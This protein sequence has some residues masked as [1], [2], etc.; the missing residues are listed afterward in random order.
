MVGLHGFE[1]VDNVRSITELMYYSDHPILITGIAYCI[2]MS[3][4]NNLWP[5]G[6]QP[7]ASPVSPT[8]C[9]S[10]LT[11][12]FFQSYF[13]LHFFPLGG[14]WSSLSSRDGWGGASL[15]VEIKVIKDLP[16]PPPVGQL[17]STPTVVEELESPTQTAQ[18]PPG[19]TC[20]DQHHHGGCCAH[21]FLHHSH[22]PATLS[23]FTVSPLTD[24][25]PIHHVSLV[26][27]EW[28]NRVHH[29]H[30]VVFNHC[31]CQ[32]ILYKGK[33]VHLYSSI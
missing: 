29:H 24:P 11:S 1:G 30:C 13:P 17:N 23:P 4:I 19:Q 18:A 12:L 32:Y 21:I 25:A 27:Y 7:A 5:L 3:V 28:G 22:L 15:A 2:F 10:K 16:W 14:S 8:V 33:C 26:W 6:A 31:G 20:C 9:S